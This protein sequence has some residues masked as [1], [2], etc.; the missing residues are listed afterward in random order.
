MHLSVIDWLIIAAYMIFALGVGVYFSRKAGTSIQEFFVSGRNLP[1]WIAGTSMVATTFAVDTP[2]FVAGVVAREGIA[3]NWLWWNLAATHVMATIF[4]SKLWHRA[5]IITDLEL[6][7]LRYSGRPANILRGFRSLWEGILLNCI[8]MGWVMLA[9]IKVMG[10]FTDWPE[11]NVLGVLLLIAFSYSVLSG[12]WGVVMTDVIQFVIAMGASI[13]LAVIAVL[14]MDG[15]ANVK[16]KIYEIYSDKADQIFRFVPEIGSSFLPV[17]TFVAFVT[18]NWWASKTADGGGY[19]AQ[20]MF[21]AKNEKHAFLA[22]LWFTIANYC[23]RPWPWIVV[24]LVALVVYPNLEDPELSYPMMVAKYLPAGLLGLMLVSFLAAFMSTID[25]QVNWGTSILVNDFYKAF[26]K[27]DA[28]DKH[29]VLV[30]RI[31]TLILLLLGTATAMLME[32]IKGGWQLFYGMSAGIGGVYIARWFWWRVN[33]WSEITAWVTAAIAYFTLYLIHQSQPTEFYSVYGWRL[34]IVT[35]FSTVCWLMATFLTAPV[36]EDKLLEFYRR[37]K[38][39]SP[40]WKPI[41]DKAKTP[42]V[43]HYKFVD[44]LSWLSG[45][46]SVYAFLFGIGKVVLGEPLLGSLYLTVG[47]LSGAWGFRL[48]SSNGMFQK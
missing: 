8:V 24:G 23:L 47:V 14:K 7:Q 9:M 3:G 25:T 6:L 26:L 41:A 44:I 16:L 43:E 12:F 46:V 27:T 39:G 4:F 45:I 5:G 35:G 19:L 22:T 15:M 48:V 40:F 30:S 10:V 36:S 13:M 38:P 28:S 32:S 29:Y 20:R 18:V 17:T 1:W 11:W 2:L 21:A 42:D 33:A 31:V 37:A 34:I